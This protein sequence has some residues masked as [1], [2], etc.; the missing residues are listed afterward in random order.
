M[1]HR[2]N[3]YVGFLIIELIF[4]GIQELIFNTFTVSMK[5][6]IS[7]VDRERINIFYIEWLR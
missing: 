7:H 3:I 4:R 1:Y 6:N 5:H 2:Y